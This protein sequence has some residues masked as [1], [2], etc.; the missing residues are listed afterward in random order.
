MMKRVEVFTSG[1]QCA[2][3]TRAKALLDEKGVDYVELDITVDE[4]HRDELV[5]RLPRARSMPQIFIGG[6]HIG[7]TE[8]LVHLDNNDELSEMLRD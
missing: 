3:C 5:D 4:A 7:S 1:P 2:H 8:D 6:E